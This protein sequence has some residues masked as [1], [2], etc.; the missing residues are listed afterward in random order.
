MFLLLAH[1]PAGHGVYFFK[2]TFLRGQVIMDC[3][4]TDPELLGSGRIPSWNC[5]LETHLLADLCIECV[6]LGFWF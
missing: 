4:G 6:W 3:T 5:H 1:M 2:K